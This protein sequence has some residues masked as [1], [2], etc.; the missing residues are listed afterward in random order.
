MY[1]NTNQPSRCSAELTG[2]DMHL[3]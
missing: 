2:H 3:T 1:Q